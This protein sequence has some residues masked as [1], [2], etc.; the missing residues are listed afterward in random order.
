MNKNN[1]N[2]IISIIVPIYNVED[3]LKRC[4]DSII[5]Q[6]YKSLEII[7]VNDGSTDSSGEL[8]D[9]YKNKDTRI[10][11]IHKNNGG[12]SSTRNAGLEAASG[13]YIGFID[14]DDWIDSD[15]YQSL[16]ECLVNSNSDI[17]ICGVKEVRNNSI[18]KSNQVEE[19]VTLSSQEA[20]K[21]LIED[22][23]VKSFTWNKL[24]RRE[25]FKNIYFPEGKKYEDIYLMHTIFKNAATI[26]L[27]NEEKYYYMRRDDSITN[28]KTIENKYDYYNAYLKRL[29]DLRA[30]FNDYL[31]QLYQPILNLALNILS[32]SLKEKDIQRDIAD[33]LEK[34]AKEI[35]MVMPNLPKKTI[36]MYK[37]FK[38]SPKALKFSYSIYNKLK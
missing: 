16:H 2:E 24:Y 9:I 13:K 19:I 17:S 38:L 7:L 35:S 36:V 4:L 28:E 1:G 30:D 12:I 23:K 15:M 34:N 22:K 25:V 6:T 37:I 32:T 11:V 3:Y 10:K 33:F 27:L 26:T 21:L 29:N 14:S 8:C 18:I 5:G 31:P 20:I